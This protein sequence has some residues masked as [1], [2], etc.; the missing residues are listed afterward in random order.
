MESIEGKRE[1]NSSETWGCCSRLTNF[2][3]GRANSEIHLAASQSL[4]EDSGAE[5]VF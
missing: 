3:R 2:L 1:R 4:Q 5:E